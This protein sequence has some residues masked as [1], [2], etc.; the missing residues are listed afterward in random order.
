MGDVSKLTIDTAA[1]PANSGLPTE[2]IFE[3]IHQPVFSRVAHRLVENGWSVLPQEQDGRRPGTV[4]GEVIRWAREHDL[5]NRLPQEPALSRWCEQ[6]ATSNAAVV[7]GPASGGAFAIDIDVLDEQM[8]QQMTELTVQC[9]GSTPFQRVGRAPKIA[10]IYRSAERIASKAL[11]F[12]R[13]EGMS[14]ELD[15]PMLEIAGWGKA[16]TFYGF[17]H[18]TGGRFKWLDRQPTSLRSDDAPLVTAEQVRAFLAAAVKLF[19]GAEA[20][21]MTPSLSGAAA[22]IAELRMDIATQMSVPALAPST[23]WTTDADG[24]V[25]DGRHAY[26]S[27]LT[28]ATIRA[29]AD[30]VNYALQ[31]GGFD[32]RLVSN[33]ERAVVAR[34]ADTSFFDDKRTRERVED[35]V[36]SDIEQM[37]EKVSSGAMKLTQAKVGA[38]EAVTPEEYKERVASKRA[39]ID[40]A[41]ARAKEEAEEKSKARP[42]FAGA[43]FRVLGRKKEA[44][45][46]S[47]FFLSPSGD[48]LSYSA[49]GL[50]RQ[51]SLLE[52]ESE[53][54][55]FSKYAKVVGKSADGEPRMEVDWKRAAGD[56]VTASADMPFWNADRSRGRG[57]WFD[58]AAAVTVFHAGDRAYV[59]GVSTPLGQVPGDYVYD[60]LEPLAAEL[61]FSDRLTDEEG[62]GFIQLCQSLSWRQDGDRTGLLFAGWIAAALVTGGL[63]NRPH[64]CLVGEAGSGK[65][66]VNDNILAPI[67]GS[68]AFTAQASTTEAGIR[69]MLGQDARPVL[70]D[71]AEPNDP[72]AAQRLQNILNLA[73]AAYDERGASVVKA[74]SG[75]DGTQTF[76]IRSCFLFTSINA[77]VVEAA[78]ESRTIMFEL[79]P[80]RD[81]SAVTKAYKALFGTS[82]AVGPRMM[83]RLL[84]LL[85]VF[86]DACGVFHRALVRTGASDRTGCTWGVALAGAWMLENEHAPSD[87]EAD[88]A[89]TGFDFGSVAV[90]SQPV[91]EW[92]RALDTVLQM[93]LELNLDGFRERHSV[94]S[95]LSWL[96]GRDSTIGSQAGAP[97]V[98]KVIRHALGDAGI[99]LTKNRAEVRLTDTSRP[100]GQLFEDS[101]V[102]RSWSRTLMRSPGACKSPT[103]RFSERPAAA[104]SIPLDVV[105]G[106]VGEG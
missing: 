51:S 106:E 81:R 85:P 12:P 32:G 68:Y 89:L 73:R 50:M 10:L 48:I 74:S 79:T 57:V 30:S 59:D 19:G 47:Y 58:S 70:F 101:D 9:L 93:P 15:V 95:A 3:H 33:L 36:R 75:G 61:N 71:E 82:A 86:R 42:S 88:E 76:K 22:T 96:A 16:L 34:F 99:V 2:L 31:S 102:G 43:G 80:T 20:S 18:K 91:P 38:R 94:A 54:F 6:C 21:A 41:V 65:S 97:G 49:D 29:N 52:L 26:L 11:R 23:A 7:M 87:N 66:W 63:P 64:A 69:R 44:N 92:R 1:T 25:T 55:W 40:L 46:L 45:R 8:A 104:F 4:D 103:T 60:A 14:E 83:T 17:H 98:D 72:R 77:P 90:A 5:E 35:S 56:L 67:F 62:E 39:Q 84:S 100:L 27:E 28:F 37:L 24:R 105:L 78:D 53:R 13:P